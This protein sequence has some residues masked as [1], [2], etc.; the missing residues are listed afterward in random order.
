MTSPW[1]TPVWYLLLLAVFAATGC[2]VSSWTQSAQQAKQQAQQTVTQTVESAQTEL[3]EQT[4]QAGSSE[5][6]LTMDSDASLPPA[7]NPTVSAPHGQAPACYVRFTPGSDGRSSVLALQ[8]Y[9]Q[10][11]REVFP[12]FYIH[13]Q[14]ASAG[15]EGL[16]GQTVPAQMYYKSTATSPT[17]YSPLDAPL[18]LRILAVDQGQVTAEIVGG[19]LASSA[20]ATTTQIVGKFTAVESK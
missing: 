18:Q 11:E 5:I 6:T 20:D 14:V 10:A 9:K 15:L 12:S 8:S 7:T 19:A 16:A 3:Q 2:D 13:A 4:G 17:L 1:G